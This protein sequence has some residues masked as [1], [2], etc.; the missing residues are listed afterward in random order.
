MIL[1]RNPL[2]LLNG[3]KIWI[4]VVITVLFASCELFKPV[5]NGNNNTTTSSELEEVGSDKPIKNPNTKYDVDGNPIIESDSGNDNNGHSNNSS[6]N[7]TGGSNTGN[8]NNTGDGTIENPKS[9]DTIKVNEPSVDISFKY[10]YKVGIL[11]PFFAREFGT[12]AKMPRASVQGMNFYEGS[13]LALQQLSIEGIN[14]DVEVFDSR[15]SQ[16][17]VQGLVD[18]YSLSAMDLIIGPAASDNV[19]IVAEK[20]AKKDQVPMVSLNLNASIAS[21]NPYYIQ[22]SPY[23]SSHADA[24]VKYIKQN[25]ASNNVVIVVPQGGR[26]VSRMKHYYDLFNIFPNANAL[27]SG[28]NYNEFF[29]EKSGEASFKFEGLSDL[30]SVND[31]TIIIA[32]VSDVGFVSALLRTLNSTR[33]S[34]PIVV[35]GMPSWMSYE[36]LDFGV[37]ESCNVH[38]TNASFVN[39]GDEKVK[40]FKQAF[41]TE[42]NMSPTIEAYK[43]YDLTLYFGRMLNK[44]GTGFIS[45]LEDS[46][47]KLLQ[48]TFNFEKVYETGESSMGENYKIRCFENKFVHILRYNNFKYIPMNNENVFAPI[49]K[50]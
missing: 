35:F 5:S 23:F 21:E 39:R 24:T 9:D 46:D 49:D 30:L 31:T 19:R 48:T 16:G 28:N 17:V 2:Q 41:F 38:V 29:A 13:L 18:N 25:Y 1:A 11:M 22:A 32:P 33:G 27:L 15:R 37:L 26:E 40:A 42:Y 20:V 8:N 4:F 6:N 36:N 14:L 43:G 34:K 44:Y 12:A 3:S 45:N 7:G 47:D 10:A 50:D